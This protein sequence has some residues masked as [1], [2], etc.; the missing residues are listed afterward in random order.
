M[1]WPVT[2]LYSYGCSV[3]TSVFTNRDF[4]RASCFLRGPFASICLDILVY[5]ASRLLPWSAARPYYLLAI[6][7]R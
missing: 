6:E 5:A 4:A 7:S 2:I 1:G 3:F